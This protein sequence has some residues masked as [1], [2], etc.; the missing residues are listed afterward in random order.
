MQSSNDIDAIYEVGILNDQIILHGIYYLVTYG[1]NSEN[2]D[3]DDDTDDD[4]YTIAY[5]Q[6]DKY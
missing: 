6:I 3:D 1:D 4:T 5:E 2:D